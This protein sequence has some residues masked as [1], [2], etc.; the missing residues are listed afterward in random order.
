MATLK[1]D[2]ALALH[3]RLKERNTTQRAAELAAARAVAWMQGKE[4]F[5]LRRLETLCD[6]GRAM[7]QADAP[8]R[9][10]YYEYLYYV[11][12]GEVRTLQEFAR[13]VTQLASWE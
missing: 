6:T 8:E 4:D 3:R 7:G 11:E 10:A 9:Q 13:S 1:G 2:A 12:C 5:D